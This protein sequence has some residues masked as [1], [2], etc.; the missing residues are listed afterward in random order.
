[1]KPRIQG[2]LTPWKP[3]STAFSQAT[4]SGPIV[5]SSRLCLAVRVRAHGL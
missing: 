3:G 2:V 5:M 4:G 1:M